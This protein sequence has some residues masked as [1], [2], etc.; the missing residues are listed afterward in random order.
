M[1]KPESSDSSSNEEMSV[2]GSDDSMWDENSDGEKELTKIAS[3]KDVREGDFVLVEFKG[4]NRTVSNFVYLCII[5]RIMSSNDIEIMGPR[6]TDTTKK[7]FVPKEKDISLISFKQIIGKTSNPNVALT[8]D[9]TPIIH[10]NW[11]FAMYGYK[12]TQLTRRPF[13]PESFNIPIS[14]SHDLHKK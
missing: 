4:G 3:L 1:E 11:G 12:K 8:G 10:V 9:K 6:S 7:T 5:Q 13:L 2:S 14:E